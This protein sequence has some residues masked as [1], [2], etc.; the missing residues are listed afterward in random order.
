M[1]AVAEV[2]VGEEE[3]Q[4]AK[5]DLRETPEKKEKWYRQEGKV[6][7]IIAILITSLAIHTLKRSSIVEVE[8][9]LK[10][11]VYWESRWRSWEIVELK[12]PPA[13]KVVGNWNTED[14]SQVN[15]T[16]YKSNM[17]KVL[18]LNKYKGKDKPDPELWGWE[19]KIP[20][21][22]EGD[23]MDLLFYI[24]PRENDTVG[25]KGTITAW[26]REGDQHPFNVW[27]VISRVHHNV[28][29]VT[30]LTIEGKVT[31]MSLNKEVTGLVLFSVRNCSCSNG[32][33]ETL[34]Y[35]NGK[36]CQEEPLQL[37][38]Y[39]PTENTDRS[40]PYQYTA[41]TVDPKRELER[42]VIDIFNGGQEVP[43]LGKSRNKRHDKPLCSFCALFDLKDVKM[44]F[45]WTLFVTNNN[46][47][48]N[49]YS[50]NWTH[51]SFFTQYN[52]QKYEWGITVPNF[53]HTEVESW[54]KNNYTDFEERV[55]SCIFREVE[56]KNGEY[57]KIRIRNRTKGYSQWESPNFPGKWK[58]NEYGTF[59]EM[60]GNY[61]EFGHLIFMR[62]PGS[63]HT[64]MAAVLSC[65]TKVTFD[66]STLQGLMESFWWGQMT[67]LWGRD[68][69]NGNFRLA[70]P[71][72]LISIE[73]NEVQY[74][75]LRR[76][77]WDYTRIKDTY[78][79]KGHHTNF[80]HHGTKGYYYTPYDYDI[81]RSATH[82]SRFQDQVILKRTLIKDKTSNQTRVQMNK[83]HTNWWD[84]RYKGRYC[85][86]WYQ[87]A[88]EVTQQGHIKEPADTLPDDNIVCDSENYP[89]L[90]PVDFTAGVELGIG[91]LFCN[92]EG[93]TSRTVLGGQVIIPSYDSLVDERYITGGYRYHGI[94]EVKSKVFQASPRWE[95][96]V[97]DQYGSCFPNSLNYGNG[98]FT[99]N[100]MFGFM[101]DGLKIVVTKVVEVAKEAAGTVV[102]AVK[103]ALLDLIPEEIWIAVYVLAG[104]ILA[105]ISLR[106]MFILNRTLACKNGAKKRYQLIRN[107]PTQEEGG[108]SK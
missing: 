106:I 48:H 86:N 85:A 59:Q 46:Y 89:S 26:W 24:S 105:V 61:Q 16:L 35:G 91:T 53:L 73:K 62:I 34:F 75:L 51:P 71:F 78:Y 82:G 74:R 77:S 93:R 68:S 94:T 25:P 42:R 45:N 95:L 54:M 58:K 18:P 107:T 72:I 84:I 63:S 52:G 60:V 39:D 31:E 7:I 32:D 87:H 102:T 66:L 4:S 92:K 80:V 6:V 108:A 37:E 27:A 9:D 23:W 29:N 3:Y 57:L 96:N 5:P 19:L 67:S 17:L 8:Y 13:H 22:R 30:C 79:R 65:R 36:L 70:Y 1:T 49:T 44:S 76:G 103:N 98:D 55:L 38:T 101:W 64:F 97:S 43:L 83:H 2:S 21:S 12:L 99:W 47:L 10:T 14:Q 20:D 104:L 100:Q 81:Q 15:F 33:N 11:Q 41:L 28:D 50:V 88:F 56:G 90:A 40:Y 69:F